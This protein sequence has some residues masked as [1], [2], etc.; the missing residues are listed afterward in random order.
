LGIVIGRTLSNFRIQE[1]ISRGAMG[2][3]YRAV[4]TRLDREPAVKVLPPE[5]MADESRRRRFVKEAKAAAAIHHPHIATIHEIDEV[6]SV[7]FI[8]ME[9][10]DGEKLSAVLARERLPVSRTLALAAELAEGLSKAHEKNV[11]HRDL[12]PANIMV[13]REGH[14]K[15]IDFGLAKLVEPFRPPAGAGSEAETGVRGETDPGQIVGTV[16]YMSPEQARGQEVDPRSDIFS[17][18]VVFYEML[19]G[20]LPFRGKTRTDTLSAILRD[21]TPRLSGIESAEELQHVINRCLAKRADERYQTTMDLLADIRRIRRETESGVRAVAEAPSRRRALSVLVGALVLIAAGLVVFWPRAPERFVPR[22]GRTIQVTREPGLELDAAIS[23]DGKLVAYAAGPQDA[24][25][26]YVKQVAGGRPVALTQDFAGEHRFPRWSPDGTRISFR[27]SLPES[28][29]IYI[30]PALGGAPRRLPTPEFT[31]ELVWSPSGEQIAFRTPDAIFVGPTEGGGARKLTDAV[32][33]SCLSWSPEGDRIAFTSGNLGYLNNLNAAPSSIWFVNVTSDKP[34]RVTDAHQDFSPV[35]EPD[36][37]SLLF[38]SDRGG[39]RDIYRV[40]IGPAG[41]P[42]SEAERLT[43]GLDV[44][45]MASSADSR[46]ISYS[47]ATLRQNIWTLPIPQKGSMSVTEARPITTRNQVVECVAVSEDGKWLAF[48]SDQAGNQS[49]YKVPVGGSEPVQ[50]TTASTIGSPSWSPDGKEIAFHTFR[51]DNRDIFVIPADGGTV[52][53]L[54]NHP[55]HE[56]Y[57]QRSPDGKRVVFHS[58]RTGVAEIYAVSKDKGVLSGETPVQLTYD[59]GWWARWSP[60]GRFIAYTRP[61][62][63]VSVISSDG[64]HPRQL[65]DFGDGPLWSKDG[66]TIYFRQSPPDERVGIWS[67]SSSGG[68]PKRL[69]RSTIPHGSS[70]PLGRAT[71]STSTSCAPSFEADVWV[72]ELEGSKK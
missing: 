53:Q 54:T 57:P 60:D 65:T 3:V 21:P 47:V 1:E 22:V 5:L 51:A 20:T 62:R 13:T 29:E 49:L 42:V 37:K 38:V 64:G 39:G 16:S 56:F 59:G 58:G 48:G 27:R 18:G 24:T 46:M 30:V 61:S 28:W 35:W 12:K 68:T 66:R 72:M 50:L 34:V 52:R 17:F 44:F 11:V 32:A 31:G 19:S 71:A 70:T 33:P 10:I 4:D 9:L 55:A 26:I 45:T 43:T 14:V 7:D 6:A 25:R 40:S 23:P 15:I 36:G 2:V 67:V 41:E 69:V 63:G 8:V